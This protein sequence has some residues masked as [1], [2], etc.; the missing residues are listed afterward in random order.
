MN[1]SLPCWLAGDN[2]LKISDLQFDTKN[3]NKGTARGRKAVQASLLKF[4]SGRSVLIDRD[5]HLIAGNK[6][7]Q[8]AASAGIEDVIVVK[9]DGSQLV[10]VMRTDLSINDPKAIALAIADNR[11]AEIGLEWDP[12][13]MSEF[14]ADGLD[15][16]PFFTDAELAD[17]LGEKEPTPQ[18][19]DAEWAGMPEYTN[20]DTSG[21]RHIMVHFMSLKDVEDFAKLVQQNITDKTKY[22][23]F[24]ELKPMAASSYKWVDGGE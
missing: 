12:A 20:E 15:L 17:T 6:T 2:K 19:A 4:G 8:Q 3:A 21:V 23:Y 13:V 24:P 14:S 7:A 22:I 5:G 16:K 1:Y 11:T 18:D 10:A 9:S